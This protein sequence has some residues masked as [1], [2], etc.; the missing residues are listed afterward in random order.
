MTGTGRNSPFDLANKATSESGFTDDGSEPN[1]GTEDGSNDGD[2]TN[3]GSKMDEFEGGKSISNSTVTED[4]LARLHTDIG[5]V[6]CLINTTTGV[7]RDLAQ[8]DLL[9]LQQLLEEKQQ[10]MT[11]EGIPIGEEVGDLTGKLF[12]VPN[13]ILGRCEIGGSD[14]VN[15]LAK[16]VLNSNTA[17]NALSSLHTGAINNTVTPVW[18]YSQ[19]QARRVSIAAIP[20]SI[21]K[22]IR[23]F[24]TVRA[25]ESL[26]NSTKFQV[27]WSKFNSVPY[28]SDTPVS[29]IMD[30]ISALD[31]K[32]EDWTKTLE[33]RNVLNN[34]FCALS[35][36][37]PEIF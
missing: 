26:T 3:G 23:P 8:E 36:T 4:D 13:P 22:K 19:H 29:T 16:Q 28:S 1:S 14:T 24:K 10:L 15:M 6:Q 7:E 18:K 32:R 11:G 12:A 17:A 21:W 33:A 35:K 9:K 37:S 2:L 25:I 34:T 5:D 20:T 30:F 27:L 31:K